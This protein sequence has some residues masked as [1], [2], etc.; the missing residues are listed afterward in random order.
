MNERENVVL[1][2]LP[3]EQNFGCTFVVATVGAMLVVV[4]DGNCLVGH[5]LHAFPDINALIFFAWVHFWL[6]LLAK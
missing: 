5:D 1:I 4:Q 6:R 3:V 2:L